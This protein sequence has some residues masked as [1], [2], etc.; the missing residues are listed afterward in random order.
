MDTVSNI[1]SLLE[2]SSLSTKIAF[3]SFVA[4]KIT[5][6]CAMFSLFG[7]S[8]DLARNLLVSAASF[9]FISLFFCL[10]DWARNNRATEKSLDLDK[11]LKDLISQGKLE[12]LLILAAKTKENKQ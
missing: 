12:E 8:R 7:P 9:L 6:I 2:V 11:T 10:Y 1:P 5:G 4:A 3:F